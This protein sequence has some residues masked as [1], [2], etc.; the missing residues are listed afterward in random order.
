MIQN[1]RQFLSRMTAFLAA[2]GL[3]PFVLADDDEHEHDGHGS[4]TPGASPAPLP[5]TGL[6]GRVVV[7]GGGMAGAAVAKFL[8]LWGGTGVQVTLVERE[9]RYTS[10]ILSNLVLTDAVAM[11]S[12]EFDYA[13]LATTYGI[14]VM[15]GDALAADPV[16]RK[17]T[18]ATASGL[19]VLDY[20]RLVVAPGIDFAYPGGPGDSRGACPRAPRLAGRPAD[21]AAARADPGHARGRDVHHDGA[22]GA[23]PLPAGAL[24]ARLRRGR[25]AQA[26]PAGLEG[27]RAGREP[28]PSPPSARASRAPST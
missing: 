18:V 27:D 7:V 14:S 6:T 26:Q 20:D 23:V 2:A 1:R 15:L 24:R 10:N 28:R 5:A 22:P 16:A 17:L 21:P 13:A 25:L 19:Q 4:T 3:P 8:R 9:P 12:L 11:T